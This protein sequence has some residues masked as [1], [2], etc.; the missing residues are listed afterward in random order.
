MNAAELSVPTR[1]R[2]IRWGLALLTLALAV[3]AIAW[4]VRES[5]RARPPVDELIELADAGKLVEAASRGRDLVARYPEDGPTRLLLA[6]I[7]LKLPDSQP[8]KSGRDSA[9]L[10]QEAIVHL[11]RVKPDKPR[12]AATF[13]LTRGNALDLLGRLDEAEADWL[14]AL[15]I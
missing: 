4:G 14:E 1:V 12:M 13:H 3:G 6:Q 7:L 11:D 5:S 10:V 15:R 9:G 8:S 2:T